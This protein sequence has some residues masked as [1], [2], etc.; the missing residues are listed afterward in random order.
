[1]TGISGMAITGPGRRKKRHDRPPRE[2]NM[3]GINRSPS[4]S[5]WR[6]SEPIHRSTATR[7]SGKKGL[8]GDDGS[9]NADGWLSPLVFFRAR[10]GSGDREGELASGEGGGGGLGGQDWDIGGGRHAT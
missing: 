8:V 6:G 9:D 7:E 10:A 5:W 3:A 2:G 1:M 4:P